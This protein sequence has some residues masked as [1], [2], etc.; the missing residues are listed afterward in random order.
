MLLYL[1]LH[2]QELM[3]GKQLLTCTLLPSE[4][5]GLYVQFLCLG[6]IKSPSHVVKH[7]TWSL[8]LFFFQNQEGQLKSLKAL[9][10]TT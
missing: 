5:D 8:F 9:S 1:M 4:A 7:S 3:L 6:V 10:D 2:L